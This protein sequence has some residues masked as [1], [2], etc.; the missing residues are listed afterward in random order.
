M[1]MPM[2]D[3]TRMIIKATKETGLTPDQLVSMWID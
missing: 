3:F 1:F 2:D